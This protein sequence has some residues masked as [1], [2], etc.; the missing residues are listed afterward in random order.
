LARALTMN[1]V[2]RI[3][4]ENREMLARGGRDSE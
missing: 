1:G 2:G 3:L 4:F